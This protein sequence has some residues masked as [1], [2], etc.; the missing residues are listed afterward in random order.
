ME[1]FLKSVILLR[2]F[3]YIMLTDLMMVRVE[4]LLVR[5]ITGILGYHQ[6]LYFLDDALTVPNSY[7]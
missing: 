6:S 2:I 4:T 3:S 7:I 1:V 5:L